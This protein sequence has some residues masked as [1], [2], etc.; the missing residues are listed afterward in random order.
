MNV[1]ERPGRDEPVVGH[2]H[3][4]LRAADDEDDWAWRRRIRSNATTRR[5]YRAVVFVVGLLF[6]LGG[7]ALIPFPGPG[8]V[9][10]IIGLA[11]WA[12]EFEFAERWLGFVKVRVRAWETWVKAQSL[13][14]R[15]LLGL[16]LIVFLAGVLWL[17]LKFSGVP[18]W[19]PDAAENW[20]HTVARL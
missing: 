3:H 10:V 12:S 2:E 11:I 18:T 19:L 8:W 14:V 4:V 9:I 20:L 17:S 15:S 13:V 6:L 5:A 16:A 7:A 1:E